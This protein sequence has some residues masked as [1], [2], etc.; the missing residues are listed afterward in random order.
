M[1]GAHLGQTALDPTFEALMRSQFGSQDDDLPLRMALKALDDALPNT[2][3]QETPNQPPNQSLEEAISQLNQIQEKLEDQHHFQVQRQKFKNAIETQNQLIHA[4]DKSMQRIQLQAQREEASPQLLV[5]GKAISPTPSPSKQE[6]PEAQAVGSFK[7]TDEGEHVDQVASAAERLVHEL[8]EEILQQDDTNLPFLLRLLH[9]L[10]GIAGSL[11]PSQRME[12]LELV[13]RLSLSVGDGSAALGDADPYAWIEEELEVHDDICDDHKEEPVDEDEETFL[14]ADEESCEA[15]EDGSE[16]ELEEEPAKKADDSESGD[17]SF[18]DREPDEDSTHLA[19]TRMVELVQ[20]VEMSQ[21]QELCESIGVDS[22]GS[23]F[24]LMERVLQA[25]KAGRDDQ[26]ASWAEEVDSAG[27]P[28]TARGPPGQ[29]PFYYVASPPR[30]KSPAATS[31]T[32]AAAGPPQPNRQVH[33]SATVANKT[34]T[35][36]HN[37]Q[38]S[39][40]INTSPLAASADEA[41]D[42]DFLDDEFDDIEKEID[43][44]VDTKDRYG[45]SDHPSVGDWATAMLPGKSATSSD[46]SLLSGGTDATND[47]TYDTDGGEAEISVSDLPNE[48]LSLEGAT[49]A[50]GPTLELLRDRLAAMDAR[51]G[52]QLAP[53]AG[54]EMDEQKLAFLAERRRVEELGL[55]SGS[56]LAGDPDEGVDPRDHTGMESSDQNEHINQRLLASF[57]E[58]LD[59]LGRAYCPALDRACESSNSPSST[60]L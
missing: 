3:P 4:I 13:Q 2:H 33:I 7:D 23:R 5:Q 28:K 36:D 27:R 57:K 20:D 26:E 32:I 31:P 42:A 21:L 43:F 39:P 48:R 55:G 14:P 11:A 58:S 49:E 1:K 10:S 18:Y 51:E 38:R 50:L 29:D 17:D 54:L 40:L 16:L 60:K 24:E 6:I 25:L 41:F 44:G 47:G 34:P 35:A 45:T 22:D 46:W 56:E 19:A 12:V 59:R 53:A 8:L 30:S 52:P 15:D 37:K 9:G